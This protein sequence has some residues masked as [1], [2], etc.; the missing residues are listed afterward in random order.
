MRRNCLITLVLASAFLA[1]CA[2]PAIVKPEAPTPTATRLP[3][4]SP[5]PTPAAVLE[6]SATSSYSDPVGSLRF[7]FQ[8]TNISPFPVERV[9][10]TVYLEDGEG[11]LIAQQRAYAK[12]DLLKPGESAPVLVVFFLTSPEYARYD[13]AAEGHSADYLSEHLHPALEIEGLSGRVG[14]W[15]PYEVLGRVLNA[16]EHDVE[17]V[18]VTANCFDSQGRTTAIVSGAPEQRS[19]PAGE[20]SDFLLSVGSMAGEI[21][22]CEALVEGLIPY[23]Q[24]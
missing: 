20:S 2:S 9:C 8:V 14:E 21:A 23:G 22:H 24:D 19:I 6:I 15:V 4:P 16:G 1:A 11:E 5:T 7:L 3:G 10:A 18:M 13:I 12:S 17:S